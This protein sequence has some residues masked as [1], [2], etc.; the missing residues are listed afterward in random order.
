MVFLV[1]GSKPSFLLIEPLAIIHYAA[2]GRVAGRRDLHKVQTSLASSANCLESWQDTYLI[3][4][5]IYQAD[6]FGSDPFVYP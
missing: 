3:V 2:D 5:F 4:G 1:G 6:S